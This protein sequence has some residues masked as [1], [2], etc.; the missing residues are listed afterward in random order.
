M[1]FLIF[2][3]ALL[4]IRILFVPFALLHE[5]LASRRQRNGNLGVLPDQPSVSV[6]VPAHNEETVLESCVSSIVG[7]G[8]E[9]MEVIIVDDGSKD[10]TRE[11][12]EE[13]E[14]TYPQV[15][16][17]YQ[18]NAGKGAALNHGYR[19]SS[20]EFLMFIDSDSVFTPETVPEM[21][22]AFHNDRVGAVCGDD[23]PVNLNRVLTRF[24]ALITHVGTGLVRRAFDILRVVPVISGNCGTF[25][26]SCLDQIA[27]REPGHPLRE[28]TIGED[29]DLTWQIHETD[30]RITF[31]PRALVYAESPSS[32]KALWKQR[33]RW[34]RG[35]IQGFK[36]H[37]R[38]MF[39]LKY[40][41]FGPY[42]WFAAMTMLLVPVLQVV[43]LV[44]AVFELP[45]ADFSIWGIILGSGLVLSFVLL[46]IAMAMS[47]SLGDLRHV[48]TLPVWPVYSLLMSFTMISAMQKEITNAEQVWNKPERTGV[49]SQK[50]ITVSKPKAIASVANNV[51]LEQYVH[52]WPK[53]T[54][55]PRISH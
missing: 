25:R 15:R 55:S 22:K 13:L 14:R 7:A 47:N 23:R 52:N 33:V 53:T 1:W 26:R 21:L 10:R 41:S 32:I 29:L 37:W 50:N 42:L 18:D 46:V 27:Q 3:L 24:L 5:L 31:A 28:D 20:G 38:A 51:G 54:R 44:V 8:Y 48:W 9:K 36:Y 6:V 49:I 45:T 43:L 11:I 12:G 16:Y 35:L 4:L 2:T 19:E 34:A 30:W 39:T 40:G 17:I